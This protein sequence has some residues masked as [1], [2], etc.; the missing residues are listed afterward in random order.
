MDRMREK[1]VKWIVVLLVSWQVLLLA[2]CGRNAGVMPEGGKGHRERTEEREGEEMKI[3]EEYLK[4]EFG[5]SDEELE[6]I[7]LEDFLELYDFN[8]DNIQGENVSFWLE[9]YRDRLNGKFTA[10]YSQIGIGKEREKLVEEDAEKIVRFVWEQ[11]YNETGDYIVIDFETGRVFAGREKGTINYL[12]EED[13]TAEANDVF[14]E[15]MLSCF[16]EYDV[17]SWWDLPKHKQASEEIHGS[18]NIT[19][20]LEDGR[21]CGL[22]GEN[23]AEEDAPKTLIPFIEEMWKLSGVK[24]E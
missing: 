18:W 23:P 12:T 6:G 13:M 8:M 19:I 3:T 16:S 17:Y 1:T 4:E 10:D 21:I 11:A 22:W 9:R 20:E 24:E 14:K 2:S 15:Q 7:N 5:I